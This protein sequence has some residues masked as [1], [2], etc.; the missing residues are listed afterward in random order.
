MVPLSWLQCLFEGISTLKLQI[1]P[2]VWR[3]YGVKI[4]FRVSGLGLWTQTLNLA[5]A[6]ITLAACS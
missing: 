1:R 5:E 6:F 2:F 3:V 4:W